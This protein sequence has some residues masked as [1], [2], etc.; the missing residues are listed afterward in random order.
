MGVGGVGGG[1][2]ASSQEHCDHCYK[3][4]NRKKRMFPMHCERDEK[5]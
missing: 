5:P 2:D 1:E 4:M 3:P